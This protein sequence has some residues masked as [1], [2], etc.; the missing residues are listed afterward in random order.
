MSCGD[1][2]SGLDVVAEQLEAWHAHDIASVHNES[3]EGSSTFANISGAC[4][5]AAKAEA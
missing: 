2:L 3:E 1:L 4:I 5:L